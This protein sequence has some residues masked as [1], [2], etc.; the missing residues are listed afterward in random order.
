MIDAKVSPFPPAHMTADISFANI[1]EMIVELKPPFTDA[2]TSPSAA[3][4]S[5][6]CTSM[7]VVSSPSS[8]IDVAHEGI[9]RGGREA[10]CPARTGKSRTA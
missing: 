7:S 2:C 1:I 4:V 3:V 5:D 9:M 10:P 6:A 8:G